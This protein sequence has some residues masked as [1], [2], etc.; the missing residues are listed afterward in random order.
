M[1]PEAFELE[2]VRAADD[3]LGTRVGFR[4]AAGTCT[5]QVRFH[6]T[7]GPVGNEH[8]RIAC[9]CWAMYRRVRTRYVE[10]GE[11]VPYEK[12]LDV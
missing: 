7:G 2:L 3:W 9:Y 8:D 11:S 10:H 6:H 1:P 5:T 4:L 12:R